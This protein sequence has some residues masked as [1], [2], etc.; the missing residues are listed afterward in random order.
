[1]NELDR[2]EIIIGKKN[3][4]KIKNKNIFLIGLG[5]VGGYVFESLVRSGINNITIVDGDKID[6][7]N[8]NR[9]ILALT[10]T[11][12]KEKTLTAK[13]RALE[14]NKNIN[15]KTIT[16]QVTK[17]DIKEMN[18]SQYDYVIDAC[19]TLEVKEE[20]IRICTKEK[21]KFI[22]CMGT[23][24]K[25]KPELLEIT[26]IRKTSYDPLSKKIRKMVKEENI[27][28]KIPV[29]YSKEQPIKTN[30]KK[31]G[32]NAFVPAIAGL[33]ITSYVINNIVGEK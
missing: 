23:G 27:K 25:M 3:I 31:V 32:S 14:I 6:I 13:N 29:I 16:K 4:E 22:S 30:T 28:G 20:I 15:I 1:M 5:G 11:I 19:D 12:N 17:H 21:I 9:Q 26:D 7:T 24:N 8:I 33:M 10:S 18:L 2:L